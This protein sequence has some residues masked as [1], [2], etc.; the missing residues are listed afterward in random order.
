MKKIVFTKYSND[1][2]DCFSIRTDILQDETGGRTVRKVPMHPAAR[3]H[4]GSLS[5][6]EAG[7]DRIYGEYGYAM[8]AGRQLE[9]GSVELIYVQGETLEEKL[10]RLL[11]AG[12]VEAVIRELKNFI[13]IVRRPAADPSVGMDFV[14]TDRFR[15]VFGDAELPEGMRSTEVTDIDLICSNVIIG[16]PMTVIDYEWCFDFPIPVSYLVYRILHYHIHTKGSRAVLEEAD[17]FSWAGITAKECAVYEQMERSFQQYIDRDHV[18]LHE[19]FGE[20][21]AGK[22]RLNEMIE[23]ERYHVSNETLQVFYDRG[24]GYSAEDSYRISMEGG[25]VEAEIQIPE[26]VQGIRLDPG[27]EPGICRLGKLHFICGGGRE[28]PARFVANGHR[29][30]GDTVY[31]PKDDPQLIIREIEHGATKLLVSLHIYQADPFV[32]ERLL[33]KT[34]QQAAMREKYRRQIRE[35]ENTKAWKAY[36]AYRRLVERKKQ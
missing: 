36:R 30:E 28:L 32:M 10:D 23:R 24:A 6:W 16:D 7:L 9:D 5:R 35:M 21:A 22:L 18:P 11:E 15:E 17:L 12:Q 27:M 1:R 29:V 8:N 3:E 34:R 33:E 14:M 2:A 26:G 20:F 25:A 13:E 4:L 19:V 31:F